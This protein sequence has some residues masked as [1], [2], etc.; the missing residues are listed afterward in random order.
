MNIETRSLVVPKSYMG[1]NF[2][3]VPVYGK[4]ALVEKK[5]VPYDIYFTGGLG[6]TG[7]GEKSGELTYSFGMG[8]IFGYSKS[9]AFRWDLKWNMY[10][11]TVQD[12]NSA[13]DLVEKSGNH[14]DLFLSFGASFFFPEATYR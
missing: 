1:V 5:I 13:G 7:T 8:Q 9:L 2:K 3:W 10:S 12:R 4:M 6:L 11:A 14:N